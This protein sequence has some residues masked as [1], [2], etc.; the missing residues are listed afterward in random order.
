[1]AER[2][3]ADRVLQ[4]APDAASQKAGAKLA[5]PK[6]WEGAGCAADA[7]WGSCKGSGSKP[8]RVAVDLDGP[9]YSCTCPSRKF[10]CKHALGL[11]LLWAEGEAPEFAAE[12]LG[13]RKEKK[14]AAPAV[15]ATGA[16]TAQQR[17]GRVA[18]GV[19][20]L[21]RWLAD[22]VRQGVAGLEREGYEAGELMAARMVDAQAPG[23]AARVREAASRPGSGEGWHGRLLE[24]Y[25]E[26]WLL[27]RAYDRIDTL[28]AELGAG[29]RTRIGWTVDTAEVLREGP[30]VRDRWLVLGVQDRA[31]DKVTTR[32]Q[33]L[34]GLTTG[35]DAALFS[36]GT[37]G[38]APALSLPVGGLLDAD[39]A[40]APAAVPLR[41]VLGEKHADEGPAAEPAGLTAEEALDRYASALRA[42]PWLDAWPVVLASAVVMPDPYG[43]RVVDAVGCRLPV[44]R[45][46]TAEES[47][48]RL[49]SL[50]GGAGLTV[51]GEVGAHGF[52]PVTAWCG[53]R[54]VAL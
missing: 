24:D 33:W 17:A 42:E 25:A 22:Q 15:R 50:G 18:D 45:A 2:W 47:L 53:G 29:L 13:A 21:R 20:E 49:T 28:P 43:W 34:R 30:A 32:R 48:W 19:A 26:L 11:L 36:Y 14:E 16:K 31:A 5:A 1:M 37:P 41:A 12:W 9:A 39:L 54:A 35:R 4:L 40:F 23:L 44:D 51:F 10:P 38:Q 46:R 7:L 8:Y 52:T 6:P 3:T 27:A